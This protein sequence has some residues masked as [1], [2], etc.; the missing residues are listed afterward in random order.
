[1]IMPLMPAKCPECGGLVEVNSENRAGLCQH[2]RQPFVVEDAINTFNNYFN[3]TN[4]YNTTNNYG[5]GAIINVYEDI[6]KDFVIEAGV[7]KEYHG[8]AVDVVLPETVLEIS[9]ECFKGMKLSSIK[10]PK[11]LKNLNDVDTSLLSL[12]IDLDTDNP[13]MVVKDN[14]ILS[15]DETKIEAFIRTN[16]KTSY[17]IPET[18]VSISNTAKQ[19]QTQI[20]NI[21]CKS[22][23]LKHPD[24]CSKEAI[25]LS[26]RLGLSY[27]EK[28][29]LNEWKCSKCDRFI[30]D[31]S[32]YEYFCYSKGL[33]GS[34]GISIGF[35]NENKA[36]VKSNSFYDMWFVSSN[37]DVES[38]RAKL[39]LPLR[40]K[41]KNVHTLVL[42]SLNEGNKKYSDTFG[43]NKYR[44]S[45]SNILIALFPS[46]YRFIIEEDTGYYDSIEEKNKSLTE[47]IILSY[48][49]N[50]ISN[51]KSLEQKVELFYNGNLSKEVIESINRVK[52]EI[53]TKNNELQEEELKLQQKIQGDKWASEGRCRFC[54]GPLGHYNVIAG[55]RKCKVCKKHNW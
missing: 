51:C 23:D 12:K 32:K 17:N 33:V 31:Y 42:L 38:M 3:V 28:H 40:N 13:F 24:C 49:R 6:N 21:Y 36:V 14:L 9:S 45:I 26:K 2:C 18:V 7:L 48:V 29:D 20:S 4:N 22:Y 52:L 1:M 50:R 30:F 41:L 34:F 35:I 39:S 44:A 47:E 15:K 54:G 43:L 25:E 19:Q 27:S 55:D 37:S 10:F 11:S 8:E 5:D 53:N 46:A 16:G